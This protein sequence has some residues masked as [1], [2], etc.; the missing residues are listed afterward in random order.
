MPISSYFWEFSNGVT[1]T[2]PEPYVTFSP[3]VWDAKLTVVVDGNTY[4][5]EKTAYI[6]V[7]EINQ[8]IYDEDYL[9]YPRCLHYGWNNNHGF[10]WS[11]V[12]GDHWLWPE[13]Q[14]SILEVSEN[15]HDFKI[16][17]DLYDDRPYVLN[18]RKMAFYE[19]SYLDKGL[20]D[21]ECSVKLPE[22]KGEMDHYDVTHQ[23][24]YLKL[25]PDVGYDSISGTMTV[26]ISILV[27]GSS[28]ASETNTNIDTDNGITFLYQNDGDESKTSNQLLIKTSESKFQLVSVESYYKTNDRDRNPAINEPVAKSDIWTNLSFWLSRGSY[29]KDRVS[30]SNVERT[31]TGFLPTTG[32]DGMS[33]SAVTVLDGSYFFTTSFTR[34]SSGSIVLWVKGDIIP[35]IGGYTFTTHYTSGQWH[36]VYYNGSVN[37]FSITCGTADSYTV[38]DIRVLNSQV[39]E[40]QLNEY[41]NNMDRYL[42]RY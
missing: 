30:G 14:A 31:G 41:V 3:G 22:S 5:V 2:L 32:P 38:F 8:D 1:S 18:P 28:I 36:L 13:A 6:K 21:I 17:W 26:D 37:P 11:L 24:T 12:S 4:V 33:N 35:D 20:Y 40:E 23:E 25:V 34:L 29:I 10:G 42:P 15:G 16:V 39:T 19:D 7:Y 27:G 9:R